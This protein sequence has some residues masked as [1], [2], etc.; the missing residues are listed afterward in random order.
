M[1]KQDVNHLKLNPD[2][3]VEFISIGHYNNSDYND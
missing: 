3:Q 1:N 2:S